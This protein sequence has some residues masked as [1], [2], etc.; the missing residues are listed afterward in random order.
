MECIRKKLHSQRGVS[1]LFALLAFMVAAVVSVVIVSAA[2]TNV[3][4]VYSDRAAQQNHLTLTSAAQLVREEMK[5]TTCTITKETSG[6]TT[7][8]SYEATG[9]FAEEMKT[10]VAYVDNN[11]GEYKSPTFTMTTHGLDMKT[12]NVSYIMKVNQ[13]GTEAAQEQYDVVFTFTIDG[14]KE[15][16]FL[17]MDGTKT[18]DVLSSTATVKWGTGIIKGI[19]DAS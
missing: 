8:V 1:F 16:L 12:V 14:S 2:L 10:A 19:G 5:G 17:W 15:T 9:T 13:E 6:E 4:R 18:T 3:K 7:T 11:T